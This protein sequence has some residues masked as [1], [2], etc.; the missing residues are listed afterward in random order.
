MHLQRVMDAAY[1]VIQNYLVG[2]SRKNE[3][4]IAQHI[5]FFQSQVLTTESQSL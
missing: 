3:L 2:D 4:Y 5:P 1:G